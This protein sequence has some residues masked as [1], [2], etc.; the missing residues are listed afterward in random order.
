MTDEELQAAIQDVNE[1]MANWPRP[2]QP[3][4][5]HEVRRREMVLLS[6]LTLYKIE[7][8]RKQNDK[9]L[10]FFNTAIYGLLTSFFESY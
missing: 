6:Q 9:N 2:K 8:A 3:L 7:D 10:E 5:P 1:S 4:P